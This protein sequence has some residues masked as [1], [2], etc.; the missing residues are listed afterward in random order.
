M[1]KGTGRVRAPKRG[2]GRPPSTG[3][4]REPIFTGLLPEVVARVDAEATR[5]QRSRS[6]MLAILIEEALT[7]REKSR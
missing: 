2:P 4:K 1:A 3:P 5:D 7:A 6:V